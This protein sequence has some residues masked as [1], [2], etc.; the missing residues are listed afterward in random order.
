MS[1][2]F[3]YNLKYCECPT[4][5]L[6]CWKWFI[7]ICLCSQSDKKL[8]WGTAR[9][10][11]LV[12]TS[13]LFQIVI[14]WVAHSVATPALL[15]H[16]DARPVRLEI[17]INIWRILKYF[18]YSALCLGESLAQRR[19]GGRRGLRPRRGRQEAAG[20]YSAPGDVP[21]DNILIF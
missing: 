2:S 5:V 12:S 17:F 1:H 4:P 9:S 19:R 15:C 21:G 20:G 6:R 3:Y 13:L 18:L 11:V 7:S 10:S 16:K 8:W 14:K